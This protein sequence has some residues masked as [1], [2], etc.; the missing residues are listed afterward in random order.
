MNRFLS[1]SFLSLVDALFLLCLWF[2]QEVFY[3]VMSFN[4]VSEDTGIF[5]AAICFC[6]GHFVFSYCVPLHLPYEGKRQ[7]KVAS[8]D[9]KASG[10]ERPEVASGDEQASGHERPEVASGDQEASGHN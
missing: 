10:H 7:N 9:K 3:T 5:P 2:S 1:L 8:R 6:T 4:E